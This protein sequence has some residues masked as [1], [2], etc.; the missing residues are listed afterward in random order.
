MTEEATPA[1]P[2]DG[3]S[4][5]ERMVAVLDE[6][7]AIE[8]GESAP[9]NMGGY[10]FRGIVQVVNALKPLLG[11]HGVFV[12]PTTIDR[13]DSQRPVGQNKLM[14]AVDVHVRWTFIGLLGDRVEC[15]TWG[16]GTD[17][18]D[19]ATQKAYTAAFKS[20]LAET[21]CIADSETD[22][23]RHSVQETERAGPPPKP[24][25]PVDLGWESKEAANEK[26]KPVGERIKALADEDKARFEAWRTSEGLGWP[27]GPD[28][29]ERTDKKLAEIEA[30]WQAD[31]EPF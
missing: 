1:E 8:K 9:G 22:P 26:H 24:V 23:E 2:K 7:P 13:L 21:F 18:G 30:G 20:M 5:H 11:K 17:M 15:S 12:T 14:F 31:E 27:C 25:D 4:I 6:L 3:R 10:K 29:L 16:C 28:D 19:K